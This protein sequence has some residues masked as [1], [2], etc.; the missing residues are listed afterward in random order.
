MLEI[1]ALYR[2]WKPNIVHL[3]TS[4]AGALGRLA[5]AFPASRI[6]YTMHGYDQLR[7]EN[8]VFLGI[9]RGLRKHGGVIVAVSERDREVML[10]DGYDAR[11]VRNG[12][13]DALK[14]QPRD[15]DVIG[16][17]LALRN[18]GLPVFLMVA[19]DA[20]PKRLDLARSAAERLIGKAQIAWIG[21]E[22]LSTDP[23]N[24]HAIGIVPGAC[25]YLS[26]VDG[27]LLLSDHEGLS[28]SILEAMSAGLPSI[29]SAVA[30]IL[31]CLGDDP[32]G[33]A[34]NND[35]NS[36]VRGIGRLCADPS[37]RK[38]LGEAA[39]GRW[40]RE[41]S[42]LRMA[43]SYEAIYGELLRRDRP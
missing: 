4:K 33:I 24:F 39:R 20:R 37:L 6:V 31:E 38:R 8:R 18:Q 32:C 12:V 2:S 16:R 19:R 10:A 21:G 25:G 41:F 36:I 11:L 43:D 28:L 27:F 23:P 15:A 13:S 1:R 42:L 5:G 9:D 40:L 29:V 3:H 34:V 26:L 35:V 17:I 30:G 7:I 22:A 14:S